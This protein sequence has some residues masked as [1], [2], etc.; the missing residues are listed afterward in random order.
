MEQYL[1][2]FCNHKQ[3]NWVEL[4]PL[5]E[6]AY[7]NVIHA[8]TRMPPFW[9]DYHYHQVMQL[10]APKQPSNLMPEIQADTMAA[11]FE[12]TH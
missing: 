10:M 4:L 9:A 3:D 6:F 5:A 2:A 7:N 8:S 11:G 1:Q 12:A